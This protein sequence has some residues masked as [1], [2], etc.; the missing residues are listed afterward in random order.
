MNRNEP[1]PI[2][3]VIAASR[4]LVRE[5]RQITEEIDRLEAEIVFARVRMAVAMAAMNDLNARFDRHDLTSAF[6]RKASK[7]N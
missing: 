3:D 6:E 1:R 7:D 2:Q 5:A 4:D